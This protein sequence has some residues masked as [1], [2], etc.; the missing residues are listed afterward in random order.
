MMAN[1]NI[2]TF[3]SDIQKFINHWAQVNAALPPNK[4]LVLGKDYTLAKLQSDLSE[5]Q[6]DLTVIVPLE[7]ALQGESA[8]RDV[9]RAGIREQHRR[10]RQGVQGRLDGT[11]YVAMLPTMPAIRAS[12]GVTLKAY[13]DVL[14]I[15]QQ[16]D[17]DTERV[18]Q[19]ERPFVLGEDYGLADFAAELTRLTAA[20]SA[21]SLSNSTLSTARR[22][23][24][25]RIRTTRKPLV[26][27]SKTVKS[28]LPIGH[29]LTQN[30]PSLP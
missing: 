2:T 25:E 21:V 17:A 3:I 11:R 9:V 15:W 7:N 1:T 10:F 18:P 16:I 8:E 13:Q 24:D 28:R 26:L 14:D 27:Y 23:R 12:E 19:R 20:F 5:L 29:P 6:T 22:R 4:P 30:L